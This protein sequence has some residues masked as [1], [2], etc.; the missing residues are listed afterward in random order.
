MRL[1]IWLSALHCLANSTKRF[2]WWWL[3]LKWFHWGVWF[4]VG[5]GSVDDFGRLQCQNCLSFWLSLNSASL[6]HGWYVPNKWL[7]WRDKKNYRWIDLCQDDMRMIVDLFIHTESER[8]REW[9]KGNCLLNI[10]CVRNIGFHWNVQ[11]R[12][13]FFI[14]NS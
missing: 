4:A 6:T 11:L 1:F 12:F 7:K 2:I 10:S 5:D 8:E 13:F 14:L 9:E 3:T